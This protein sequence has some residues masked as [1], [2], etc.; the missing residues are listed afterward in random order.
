MKRILIL[1]T[2]SALCL[3]TACENTV[4]Y[5]YDSAE[6]QI[7]I[8]SQMTTDAQE[9]SIVL[10]MSYPDRIEALPDATVR[11][12]VNGTV[13]NAAH[14][15]QDPDRIDSRY[16]LYCFEAPLRAG[17]VVEVEASHGK[18]S[19]RASLTVPKA[20]EIAVADTTTIVRVVEINPYEGVSFKLEYNNLQVKA[21]IRDIPGEDSF[22]T[23]GVKK[24][25]RIT[26]VYLDDEGNRTRPDSVSVETDRY[27]WT[28]RDPILDDG[29]FSDTGESDGNLLEELLAANSM[30]C[31]SDQLF[32]DGEGTVTF[33]VSSDKRPYTTATYADVEVSLEIHLTSI[34]R[35]GYNYLR[36]LNNMEAYGYSVSPIIEPTMLPSNVE[37]GLGLV[38]VG[39]DS[40]IVLRLK[41]M[42]I[43]GGSYWF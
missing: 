36:A 38:S 3:A 40:K 25:F 31:F 43:E 10:S 9:H 8:L 37:G 42:R 24:V 28:R 29:Y 19:A 35:N 16:S 20:A 15:A 14:I 27:F 22:F 23:L 18:Q 21:L 7:T 41:P 2:L 4:H 33:L 5:E 30:H 12:I 32:R 34:D 26:H 1:S 13:Y 39:C 11:C 6:G 17:D